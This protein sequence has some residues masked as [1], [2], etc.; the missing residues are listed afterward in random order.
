MASGTINNKKQLSGSV[1]SRNASFTAKASASG[2]GSTDH[3]RLVNREL[4][5]Q[6]PISAITGL[7][8]ELDSKLNSKTAM[9]LIDEAISGKA[10]GLYFD[11]MKQ[12]ARKSYWYLTSEVDPVTKMGTKDSVISGPYDLGQ[13][14]GGGGGGVTTVSIKPHGGQ[15]PS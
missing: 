7:Q 14:G 6:H 4:E 9:P 3:N 15:Q 13:G 5:D 1:T 11:A 8:G 10:K 2:G 12:L